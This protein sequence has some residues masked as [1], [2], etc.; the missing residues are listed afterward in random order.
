MDHLRISGT[1]SSSVR[2]SQTNQ[3]EKL[4]SDATKVPKK[5]KPKGMV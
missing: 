2:L 5:L 3:F 4:K 1:E